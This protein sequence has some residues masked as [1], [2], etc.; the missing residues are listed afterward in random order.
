M[1]YTMQ[2]LVFLTCCLGV[3]KQID[4][5][6]YGHDCPGNDIEIKN[7]VKSS[8]CTDR[9]MR[10]SECQGVVRTKDSATQGCRFKSRLCP[11]PQPDLMVGSLYQKKCRYFSYCYCSNSYFCTSPCYYHFFITFTS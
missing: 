9:C 11:V 6:T 2:E 8:Y 7:D 10:W 5:I 4:S 1:N 3:H